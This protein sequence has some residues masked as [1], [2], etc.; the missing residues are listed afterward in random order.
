MLTSYTTLSTWKSFIGRNWLGRSY[1]IYVNTII[2]H[3]L[4]ISGNST[5][6][7]SKFWV[8]WNH[9]ALAAALRAP[10]VSNKREGQSQCTWRRP[11][12][13]AQGKLL[14]R[15]HQWKCAGSGCA[16]VGV[17]ILLLWLRSLVSDQVSGV[18]PFFLHLGVHVWREISHFFRV[19]KWCA[20][21]D[22][23][24]KSFYTLVTVWLA[25]RDWSG[26]SK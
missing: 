16:V 12:N 8:V 1:Q 10:R 26:A 11:S 13:H 21:I 17:D 23:D 9:W 7:C 2:A 15:P 25:N 4:L 14:N 20:G 24:W 5:T 6:W 22:L 3:F 18:V 19:F